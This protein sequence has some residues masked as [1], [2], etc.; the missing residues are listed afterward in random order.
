MK[1]P[2]K[3]VEIMNIDGVTFACKSLQA[4]MVYVKTY[5]P[6]T[7][8]IMILAWELQNRFPVIPLREGFLVQI[9]SH[10]DDGQI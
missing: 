10:A 6:I 4:R 8:C 7:I 5:D 3:D 9:C 2:D 1:L